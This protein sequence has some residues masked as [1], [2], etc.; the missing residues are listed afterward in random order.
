MKWTSKPT[1]NR[2]PDKRRPTSIRLSSQSV[3]MTEM[4]A[5]SKFQSQSAFTMPSDMTCHARVTA[6]PAP[7]KRWPGIKRARLICKPWLRNPLNQR[8][9]QTRWSM[10]LRSTECSCKNTKSCNTFSRSTRRLSRSTDIWSGQGT[11]TLS[12]WTRWWC[13]TSS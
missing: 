6:V 13:A 10:I 1:R 11:R 9:R 8:C 3:S 4:L 12:R 5:V 2:D 7:K